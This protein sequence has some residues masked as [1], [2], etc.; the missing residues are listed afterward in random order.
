[1]LTIIIIV[2]CLQS[3]SSTVKIGRK[4]GI[5]DI[6]LGDYHYHHHHH[7]HH[8]HPC[9]VAT[10]RLTDRGRSPVVSALRGGS[11]QSGVRGF[12]TRPRQGEGA[13][14]FSS[15]ES[16]LVQ[17][18]QSVLVSPSSGKHALTESRMLKIPCPPCDKR[19]LSKA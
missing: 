15:S 16:T 9:S 19:S 8:Q 5:S 14:F 2:S 10:L 7:H 4:I 3:R 1:M 13:L 17:I 6:S 12:D 18:C 11:C